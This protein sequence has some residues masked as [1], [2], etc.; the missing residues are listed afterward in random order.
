MSYH[1]IYLY[2]Q[3][4][5]INGNQNI[6][7]VIGNCG[8]V[9][10]ILYWKNFDSWRLAPIFEVK[11]NSNWRILFS[12]IITS[13]ILAAKFY[14]ETQDVVINGDV[15]KLLAK[16]NKTSSFN[17]NEMEATM[18]GL[19]DFNLFVTQQEYNKEASKLNLQVSKARQ[20][21]IALK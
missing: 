14:C 3:S 10:N 12:V 9:S 8:E 11:F 16:I 17:L 5:R 19:V 15:A 4:C 2:L 7:F 1:C 6:L 20:E 13:L 21:D 18:A